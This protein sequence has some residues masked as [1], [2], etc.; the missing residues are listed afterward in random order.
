MSVHLNLELTDH[1]NIRCRMCSQSLRDEA[2]GVPHRFMTWETW[3]AALQGLADMEDDVHLC[4]HWLG[5]PTIHPE[6]DRFIEYAFA[7]NAGNRLFAEFKLHTNGVVFPAERARLLIRLA[8]DPH[9][10]P[11]TFRFLHFSV[12]ACSPEVYARVKGA[13][14]GPLVNRNIE[15]FL[16]ERQA[17]GGRYPF[18]TLAFVVQPDNAHEAVAF[19][20]HWAGLLTSLGRPVEQTWDWPSRE[21]D[22]IYFRP[23]NCSDQAA[24]DRLHA[25]TCRRLG[26]APPGVERLRAAES[27]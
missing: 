16:R 25:E 3:R 20:D 27:F 4:P 12:D 11:G 7:Q 14:K 21:A 23:L 6:F 22:T 15:R 9:M 17:L 2:H 19:R 1:C 26:L 13:D 8:N 5:E 10:A 18:V 24:A